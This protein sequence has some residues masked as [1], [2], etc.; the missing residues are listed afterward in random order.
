[1]MSPRRNVVATAGVLVGGSGLFVR[2]A[3]NTLLCTP[4]FRSAR[5]IGEKVRRYYSPPP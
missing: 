2:T 1:V 5:F 4:A 3:R